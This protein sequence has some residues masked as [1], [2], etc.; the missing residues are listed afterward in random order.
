[1]VRGE[2]ARGAK[3]KK[4]GDG[5]GDDDDE[6]EAAL[7]ALDRAD[8]LAAALRENPEL[9]ESH[10]ELR[11]A[12]AK[13]IAEEERQR[14]NEAMKAGN[15]EE[16]VRHY[17]RALAAVVAVTGG[18]SDPA[19]SSSS[20]SSSS[21][22]A[23]LNDAASVYLSNRSAAFSSLKRWDEALADAEAAVRA[24]PSWPKAHI[25]VGEAARGRGRPGEA[26]EAFARALALG[27]GDEGVA[28][29]L[30]AARAAEA[31][32]VAERAHTFVGGGGGGGGGGGSLKRK[33]AAGD[34]GAAA[35]GGGGEKREAKAGRLS[36]AADEEED[37]EEEED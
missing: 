9:A 31:K 17:S 29:A 32:A 25:R 30:F 19:P 23:A 1:M 16:A 33:A 4:T 15:A 22:T 12:A 10:P 18:G 35:G 24:R 27:P 5:R 11:A 8:A 6:D 26:A 7:D 21:A 3:R 28:A 13:T 34:E 37:D 20:S 14:G 2:G 36:F